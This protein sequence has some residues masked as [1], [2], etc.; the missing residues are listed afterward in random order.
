MDGACGKATMTI[1]Y[2]DGTARASGG[3]VSYSGP[4]VSN[5]GGDSM[6]DFAL[7]ISGPSTIANVPVILTATLSSFTAAPVGGA[8]AYVDVVDSNGYGL[9]FFAK[10]CSGSA[11]QAGNCTSALP[12]SRVSQSIMLTPNQLYFVNVVAEGGVFG[13]DTASGVWSASVDPMVQ[14]DPTFANASDFTLQFSSNP[15]PAPEPSS[16]A[17]MATALLFLFGMA[18][19]KLRH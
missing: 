18:W 7:M 9:V 14:I 6:V 11:V 2:V 19:P 8:D 13:S 5:I 16:L 1:G 4:V 12:S 10:D 17:L 15:T 3:G